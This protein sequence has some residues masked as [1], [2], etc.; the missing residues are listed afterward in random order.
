MYAILPSP[1][2]RIPL[3]NMRGSVSTGTL[4]CGD[5]P[6]A[7]RRRRALGAV[8][9]WSLAAQ[10]VAAMTPAPPW[11]TTLF[12]PAMAVYEASQ[13]S[14]IAPSGSAQDLI[15]NL[16]TGA[17]TL[18]QMAAIQAQGAQD[19]T[20]AAG[21]NAALAAQQIALLQQNLNAYV[22]SIGGVAEAPAASTVLGLPWY[23]W[24]IV[25][26]PVAYLAVR[27]LK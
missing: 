27:G 11:W 22:A 21:G 7:G 23:V 18:A 12:P 14:Q 1:R 26:A 13:L 10:D 16:A 25:G 19:I 15:S 6:C 3:G 8:V 9:S 4:G 2:R 24:L 17:P 5:Q 20:T